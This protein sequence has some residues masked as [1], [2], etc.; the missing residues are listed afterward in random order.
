M[1]VPLTYLEFHAALVVPPLAALVVAAWLRDAAWWSRASLGGIGIMVGLAVAYTTLW[2]NLLIAEGVWWY[3]EGATTAT[4]WHAPIGEY[5]FFGLQ[6]ILA[7]LWLYQFVDADGTG[8]A[9][10]LAPGTRAVGAVAGLSVSAVGIV[11]L[12]AGTSTVYLGAI[13]AWAGPILAIQWAFGWPYLVRNWRTVAVGLAAPTLYLCLVDRL[14]IGWGL[15]TISEAH[16]L[17]LSPLGLPTEEA[18]FFLVTNVFLV[19][20]LT[21]YAWLLDRLDRSTPAAGGSRVETAVVG[22]VAI[23]WRVEG[24]GRRTFG[25]GRGRAR[26]Q[27]RARTSAGPGGTDGRKR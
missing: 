8:M 3:G 19:Q 21:L 6:P 15:W 23:A 18:V 17:G 11:L 1:S 25:V 27:A 2:D 26:A 7:A 14:A 9:L 20:G 5:L 10:G 4:V 24:R 13:L 22:L 12:F 16:T